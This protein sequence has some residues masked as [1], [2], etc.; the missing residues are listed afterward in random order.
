M[1]D[2][3][4][5]LVELTGRSAASPDAAMFSVIQG[6][7]DTIKTLSWVEVGEPC[8]AVNQGQADSWQ[9]TVKVGFTV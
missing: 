8:R 9:V 2:P 1:K 6:V 3:I 5:R 4:Y 7:Y